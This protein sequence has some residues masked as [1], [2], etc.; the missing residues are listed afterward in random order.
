MTIEFVSRKTIS[1]SFKNITAISLIPSIHQDVG[2]LLFP[3]TMPSRNFF[4]PV[5]HL[6]NHMCFW[7]LIITS[8]EQPFFIWTSLFLI[9]D[10]TTPLQTHN[11]KLTYL[12]HSLF[13]IVGLS[14]IHY[15]ICLF[16]MFLQQVHAPGSFF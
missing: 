9:A 6:L 10:H 5:Y 11:V 1:L 14:S 4:P 12:F 2:I 8:R 13:L 3:A 7:L 16:H 15:N